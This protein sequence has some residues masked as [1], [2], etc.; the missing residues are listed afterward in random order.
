MTEIG[1]DR[2]GMNLGFS[3]RGRIIRFCLFVIEEIGPDKT[4]PSKARINPS[5][6]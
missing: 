6:A 3:W 4:L 1:F 2:V 5:V